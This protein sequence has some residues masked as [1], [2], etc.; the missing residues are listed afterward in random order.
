MKVHLVREESQM[1]SWASRDDLARFLHE[2][3]QPYEDTVED[4]QR[5]L[6]GGGSSSWE[7]PTADWLE[8]L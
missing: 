1:P 7:N 2:T 6:G 8:P 5:A 3:M 4:I